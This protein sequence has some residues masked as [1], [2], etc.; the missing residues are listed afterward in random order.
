[1]NEDAG[2]AFR[3]FIDAPAADADAPKAIG[4]GGANGAMPWAAW[5]VGIAAL[6]LLKRSGEGVEVMGQT[7]AMHAPRIPERLSTSQ[8]RS[9]WVC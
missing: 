1:L 8:W 6:G 5:S 9:N 3:Q 2:I 7:P 4:D